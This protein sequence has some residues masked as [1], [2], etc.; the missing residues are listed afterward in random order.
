M[1]IVL[2][3]WFFTIVYSIFTVYHIPYNRKSTLKITGGLKINLKITPYKLNKKN[4]KN[5]ED[6]PM[7]A[8][9]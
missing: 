4:K 7:R 9:A 5:T 2:K 8:K 3:S 6:A 1:W